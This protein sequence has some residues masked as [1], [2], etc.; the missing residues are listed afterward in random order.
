MTQTTP[1]GV[2]YSRLQANLKKG[3]AASAS[4]LALSLLAQPVLA[5]TVP[6]DT[7]VV[8]GTRQI[9]QDAIALKREATTV[10]DGLSADEIGDL[11]ALSIGEALEQIA[12]VGSQREGSGATE[13]SIRGL[14]PFLGSTVIDGREATNGS[15]DRSVNF[16]QFPSELF[17]KLEVYKTQEASFI[18][19]GVAG[20]ISLSTLKPLDYGKQRLQVQAK[21][22]IGVDNL[23]IA[24]RDIGIGYRL[25]GSYVDQWEGAFGDFGISIGG[26]I[27]RQANP[28]QEARS[29]STFDACVISGLDGSSCDGSSPNEE[30]QD[31]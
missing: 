8:T 25:T 14:G 3:F 4:V 23:D 31:I 15:G 22:T 9:I 28:E 7:I 6:E 11:P 2:D 30:G 1:K 19:G 10:V 24:E 29:S 26:Q 12:S 5:Q 27:R 17:N 20:Q 16:S 18:E 21:G 13:V